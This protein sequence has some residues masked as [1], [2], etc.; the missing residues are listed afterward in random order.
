MVGPAVVLVGVA[1]WFREELLTLIGGP[2]YVVAGL[3]LVLLLVAAAV[4][5]VAAILRP[6][7]YALGKA[8]VALRV[9]VLAMLTY[10]GTFVAFSGSYGLVSVGLAAIAAAAVTLLL[11]GALVWRWSSVR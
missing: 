9:Q 3:L 10:L 8:M 2:E 11:L 7:S 4:D 6:I 5:L 1:S